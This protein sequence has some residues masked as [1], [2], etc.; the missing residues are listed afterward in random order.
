MISWIQRYFQPHFRTIFALILGVMIVSFIFTI[1][2][3]PGIGHSDSSRTRSKPFFGYNLESTDDQH[4]IFGD[5]AL[6]VYLRYRIPVNEMAR[7]EPYALER[8]ASISL[9][10]QLHIP[11]PSEDV[12]ADYI[13]TMGAFAN[14]NGEFDPNLYNSFRETQVLSGFDST[15]TVA[16]VSRVLTDDWRAEQVRKLL[17]GPG[18]VL[19]GDIKAQLA[20]DDTQWT[21]A[22]ASADYAKYAPALAPTPAEITKFFEANPARYQI[23]DR[24]SVDYLAFPAADFVPQVHVTDTEVRD[25]YDANPARFPKP[26]ASKPLAKS[27]PDSD[28]AIVRPQVEATLKLE[29]AQNLAAQAASDI[30]LALYNEKI[31]GV[32]P[33]LDA[34]LAEHHLA[35]KS[36]A[37]FAADAP[38]AELGGS[39]EAASQ[40]FRLDKAHFFSDAIATPDGSVILLWKET[41]AAYTPLLSEVQ[42]K[43]TADYKEAQKKNL[44]ISDLG[45]TIHDQ[46]VARLKAGYTFEKAVTA[47]NVIATITPTAG[48]QLEVKT[49][50]PFT[51]RQPPKD[52]AKAIRDNLD[53]LET[54]DVSDLIFSDNKGWFIYVVARKG[55]DLTEANPQFASTRAALAPRVA[56]DTLG[57]T[58]VELIT[59][60]QKKSA[61]ADTP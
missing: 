19:P 54:G 11:A 8:T 43:V 27:T 53:R 49:F 46:L 48:V 39:P 29:R 32:T 12:L 24:V 30:A 44:F 10:D 4:R 57:T 25:Y 26:A 6:S 16:D 34:F 28:F 55:P 40:A 33:Q 37:P 50:P 22:V 51:Q 23:P 7:L 47:A 1:G 38:P 9:A 3:T 21:L 5:A 17:G 15:A 52:L 60:E 42:D 36:L 20:R 2:A 13:K 59:R 35:L 41:L 58:L 14:A 45:K 61:A 31:D 56:K 18:Y